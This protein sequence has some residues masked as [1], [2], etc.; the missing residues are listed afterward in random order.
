VLAGF[1]PLAPTLHFARRH[2][3]LSPRHELWHLLALPAGLAA[4]AAVQR[5]LGS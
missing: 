3:L 2:A 4:G 1:V 5:L